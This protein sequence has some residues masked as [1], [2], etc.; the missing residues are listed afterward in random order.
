MNLPLSVG[1]AVSIAA[2]ACA[3]TCVHADFS[4]AISP[5]RFE[6][7]A[8]PGERVRQTIEITNAST[9]PGTLLIRTADWTFRSDDTVVLE[10]ELRAGSCRPWVAIERRELTVPP[11]QPYRFRFEVAPPAGQA[12]V[13]C[14]FAIMLE[15]KESSFAGATQS[16]PLG[17][18]VGVIVYVR[19]GDVAPELSVQDGRVEVRNGSPV[20]VIDVRNSGTAHGRL[21]GFLTGTDAQGQPL[22]VSA[23]NTPIL[24]GETRSIALKLTRQGDPNT[25]VQAAFPITVKGKLE[26][27]KGRSTE[28]DRRF[29]K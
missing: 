3:A 15:G 23:A 20:A 28:L 27:G 12:P 29:S 25:V 7:T 9:T 10:D 26:W 14:R 19:V 8:K 1:Q 16:V 5:P 18:R 6:L 11:R 2:L 22:D 4:F 13:E 17:A 21:D 24:P